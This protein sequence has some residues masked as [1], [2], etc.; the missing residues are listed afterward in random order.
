MISFKACGY[1][2]FVDAKRSMQQNT[3]SIF[4]TISFL[5]FLYNICL[6]A[7]GFYRQNEWK[8]DA[9]LASDLAER[10]MAALGE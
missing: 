2:I 5:E 4:D 3:D 1:Y 7:E 6:A 8:Q 10:I 9:E